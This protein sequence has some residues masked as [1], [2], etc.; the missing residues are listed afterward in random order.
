MDFVRSLVLEVPH[1]LPIVLKVFNWK[2]VAS[3]EIH[4]LA[5]SLKQEEV[6]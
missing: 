6:V 4:I 2:E 5:L 3:Y 1:C